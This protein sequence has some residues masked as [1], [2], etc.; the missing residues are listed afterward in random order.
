[1]YESRRSRAAAEHAERRTNESI[2][3]V[4]L[5]GGRIERADLWTAVAY[6]HNGA[7][8]GM[9]KPCCEH[10]W[11]SLLRETGR[12]PAATPDSFCGKFRSW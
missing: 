6:F 9:E 2:I 5:S 4:Y 10:S 11:A 3:K 12:V 7:G 1:M 8:S